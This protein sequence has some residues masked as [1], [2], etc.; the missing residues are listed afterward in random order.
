MADFLRITTPVQGP[1]NTVKSNPITPNDQTIQNIVDPTKVTRPDGQPGYMDS[2][3]SSDNQYLLNY[4]SNF[5]KFVSA[6]RN[7]PSL[8]DMLT[9]I[10]FHQEETLV[11]AG[12]R[13]NFAEEINEFM[14]LLQM[15]EPEVLDFL[16]NQFSS[17]ARFKGP[18][19]DALRQIMAET[20][21]P[22]LKGNIINFLKKYND[23]VS[24]KHILG[25]ILQNLNDISKNI[26]KSYR[27]PLDVMLENL[28]KD[29]SQESHDNNLLLMKKDILPYLSE[30][31]SRT[32]DLGKARDIITLL[33]LNI[34][35]YEN[36]SKE[37]LKQYFD[38]LLGFKNMKDRFGNMGT[39][40]LDAVMHQEMN[41]P[42]T[43]GAELA[44]KL[45]HIIKQGLTGEGGHEA[46]AVFENVVNSMLINESVYMPL[47]HIMVPANIDGQLLFSELWVDPNAEEDG[48]SSSDENA[49]KLLIKFDIKDVGFFDLILNVKKE[50]LDLQLF[51]PEKLSAFEKE[52][53]KGILDIAERNGFTFR[54]F[55]I[56]KSI[57]PKTLSEVFPKLYERKNAINVKI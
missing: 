47:M 36:G 48:G 2:Q 13:S 24:E 3:D 50:F 5:E 4:G 9:S 41:H 43:K 23:V 31:V 30:Y 17:A 44:D 55:Q 32:H 1:E 14:Q 34:A 26:P 7:T 38:F 51:Y 19:F 46:K 10:F 8:T 16:K 15:S 57:R 53:K 56:D 12:L 40:I 6:L 33:T 22:E 11:S 27:A 45:L 18:F 37:E 54:F 49:A 42:T 25:N 29:G 35:R 39:Q 28:M 20:N 21:S 52:I